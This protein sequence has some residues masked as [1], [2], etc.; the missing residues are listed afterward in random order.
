MHLATWRLLTTVFAVSWALAAALAIDHAA[1]TSFLLWLEHWSGDLRTAYFADRL[2]SQHPGVAVI[3]ITDETLAAFPYRLPVDRGYL[4]RL[5]T[6]LADMK[7]RA[8]GIDLLALRATEPEKDRAFVAAIASAPVPIAVAVA[9]ARVSLSEAERTYQSEFLKASGAQPGFANL[10]VGNDQIVRYIAAPQPGNA[11]NQSL[12]AA[13]TNA[14]PSP[15][16]APRRIAWL[17]KPN[18]NSDT[19]LTLPA[20]LVQPP[21]LAGPSPTAAAFA[22]LIKDRVVL[23]GGMLPDVDRHLTPLPEWEGEEVPGVLLHAQAVAQI[24]DGRDIRRLSREP[25]MW[26]YGGIAL[27]GIWLGIRFGWVAYSAFGGTILLMIAAADI[28]LFVWTRQFLPFGA[29]AVALM[30]GLIG[31]VLLRSTARLQRLGRVA[32]AAA[33]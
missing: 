29:C 25:L 10:L 32:R 8:I 24:L 28:A 14:D 2:P 6:T 26:I 20:H 9:D 3:G 30:A 5:V 22:R 31:G 11:Y 19:F 23:I 21:A 33:E 1:R 13:L 16:N 17:L 7:P 27:V 18:D 15:P 12:A 4:A